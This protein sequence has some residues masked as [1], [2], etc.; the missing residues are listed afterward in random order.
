M[1]DKADLEKSFPGSG[2]LVSKTRWVG[3]Q[4]VGTTATKFILR[5]QE[6]NAGLVKAVVVID[7]EVRG[8]PEFEV[9]G[10]LQGSYLTLR[11][12]NPVQ[13]RILA[14]EFEGLLMGDGQIA[15]RFAA[16]SPKNVWGGTIRLNKA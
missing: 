15:L 10:E 13:G 14:A 6:V 7:P 3:S 16:R 5:V 12:S 4:Q 2:E 1:A 9:T 8:H 11:L